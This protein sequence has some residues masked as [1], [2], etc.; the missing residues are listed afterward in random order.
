MR[1][2]PMPF[3][4]AERYFTPVIGLILVW[5]GDIAAGQQAIAPLRSVG[6][7]IVNAV[8]P[9]PYILC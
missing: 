4:P 8:R 7:L 9:A 2:A 6:S 1:L 3:L 5:A